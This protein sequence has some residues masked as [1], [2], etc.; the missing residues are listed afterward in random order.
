MMK[1]YPT[2][3]S[4]VHLC[5]SNNIT[6]TQLY[7]LCPGNTILLSWFTIFIV[8]RIIMKKFQSDHKG[9]RKNMNWMMAMIIMKMVIKHHQGYDY[10]FFLNVIPSSS[11]EYMKHSE[12]VNIHNII[13]LKKRMILL[14]LTKILEFYSQFFPTSTTTLSMVSLKSHPCETHTDTHTSWVSAWVFTMKN[15][16]DEFMIILLRL[17]NGQWKHV[18]LNTWSL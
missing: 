4:Q 12:T 1:I 6:L 2:I 11:L 13:P 10:S 7:F 15:L 18:K 17:I 9:S 14:R 8:I 16:R 3:S 5:C